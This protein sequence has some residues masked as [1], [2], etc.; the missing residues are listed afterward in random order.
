MECALVTGANGFV[1]S[2]LVRELREQGY[3]VR[4]LVRR[5]ADLRL[6]RE[7]NPETSSPIGEGD[8][9][10]NF[11]EQKFCELNA[12]ELNVDGRKSPGAG[13]D[14]SGP[15]S[16]ESEPAPPRGIEKRKEQ[17][18]VTDGGDVRDPDTTGS[19]PFGR[20]SVVEGDLADPGT[21]ARVIDGCTMVFHVAGVTIESGKQRLFSWNTDAAG[22]I[23]EAC[24][25]TTSVPTLV[26]VS[27]LAAT[28]VS[29]ID[30]VRTENDPPRPVSRY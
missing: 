30:H 19:V 14:I 27:S 1:G 5:G 24:R 13:T 7:L 9:G 21:L 22:W 17:S 6:L 29:P 18:V 26:F 12:D 20:V 4:A 10:Q 25:R 23:A 28:G 2:H 11:R 16:R 8:N 15:E 3:S